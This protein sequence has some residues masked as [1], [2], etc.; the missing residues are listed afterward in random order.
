M[1]RYQCDTLYL[2]PLTREKV[3]EHLPVLSEDSRRA[4]NN[5]YYARRSKLAMMKAIPVPLDK[6]FWPN[7]HEDS[8]SAES[9][10]SVQCG[11]CG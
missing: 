5:A 9:E 4:Y 6:R 1:R 11:G 8:S 2:T 3:I 7:P 10:C